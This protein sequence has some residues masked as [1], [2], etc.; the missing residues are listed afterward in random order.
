MSLAYQHKN[1]A[2]V[3]YFIGKEPTLINEDKEF[4]VDVVRHDD[5][6]MVEFLIDKSIHLDVQERVHK[7]T[8][9]M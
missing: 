3:E 7:N 6:E 5:S 2:L 1:Y 9:L 8:A 4:F